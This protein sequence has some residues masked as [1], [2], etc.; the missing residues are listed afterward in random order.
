[1]E[2]W[3][4]SRKNLKRV[5]WQ[6]RYLYIRSKRP[7]WFALRACVGMFCILPFMPQEPTTIPAVFCAG[8]LFAML[9]SANRPLACWQL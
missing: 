3:R 5:L 9:T 4:L 6:A 8:L 7:V 1:M 2:L